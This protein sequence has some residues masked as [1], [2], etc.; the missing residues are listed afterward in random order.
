MVACLNP[1]I[2]KI[3]SSSQS[4]RLVSGKEKKTQTSCGPTCSP[5][6]SASTPRAVVAMG[7]RGQEGQHHL[8][9]GLDGDLQDFVTCIQLSSKNYPV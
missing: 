1:D 6:P 8:E 4:L 9:G 7:R 2:S 3:Q 5:A